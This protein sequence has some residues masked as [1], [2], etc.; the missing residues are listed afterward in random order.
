MTHEQLKKAFFEIFN[1]E[2][3]LDMDD[4]QVMWEALMLKNNIP[5]PESWQKFINDINCMSAEKW[6]FFSNTFNACFENQ[7]INELGKEDYEWKMHCLNN[8]I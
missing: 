3:E 6:S 7:E 4:I 1:I 5:Q 8:H 2:S